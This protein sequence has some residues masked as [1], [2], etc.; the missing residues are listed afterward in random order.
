[1]T[2]AIH[3]K[4]E[5]AEILIQALPYIRK[6][7]GKIVVVKYGGNAMENPEMQKAVMEDVVLMTMIG[8]KV[9]IVHGGGI[10]IAAALKKLGMESRFINGKRVTDEATMEVVQSVLAGKVNKNL[11]KMLNAAGCKA[12]GVCGIDGNMLIAQQMSREMGEVGTITYVNT[13]LI[14]DLLD[15]GYVPVITSIATDGRGRS[16]NVNA[17]TAA[18]AVA[19][20]LKAEA[21]VAMTNIN[22][23]MRDVNDPDS[24]ISKVSVDDAAELE[25]EG[26]IAG[27]MIPKIECCI[28]AINAGVKKVFVINGTVPH[29]ILVEFLTD[30]GSGTMF[31]P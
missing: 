30:E 11:T 27:G 6:Y 1:M 17:D 23:V 5:T 20:A 26:V 28:D 29:S 8:I 9:V 21:M 25:K 15:S 19:G 10:D 18:S 16:F 24:L 22:G 12:V 31:V 13:K 4:T 3:S 7:N 14:H 2:K